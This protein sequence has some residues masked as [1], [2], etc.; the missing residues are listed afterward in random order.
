MRKI[1]AIRRDMLSLRAQSK[2]DADLKCVN[3]AVSDFIEGYKLQKKG[4]DIRV[5]LDPIY[6]GQ[7]SFGV[8]SNRSWV[9]DELITE[10][11]LSKCIAAAKESGR[12]VHITIVDTN[13][14]LSPK[15]DRTGFIPELSRNFTA[16]T[17]EPRTRDHATLCR[18]NLFG[19][20][21]LLIDAVKEGLVTY[22]LV[23]GLRHAGYGYGSEIDAAM[24]YA[25]NIIVDD[26]TIHIVSCSFGGSNPGQYDAIAKKA[27]DAGR[28]VI[29]S[30]AAGN[31]GGD[32]DDDRVG[33]PAKG[34]YYFAVGSTDKN[35]KPSQFSSRGPL[36]D[37]MAPGGSTPSVD[38]DGVPVNWSGTSSACPNLA[39]VAALVYLENGDLNTHENMGAFLTMFAEDML[40]DGRDSV[41]GYGFAYLPSYINQSPGSPS[42]PEPEPDPVLT[43]YEIRM[44]VDRPLCGQ[45]K[46]HES[47]KNWRWLQLSQLQYLASFHGTSYSEVQQMA[48]EV[49]RTYFW[50]FRGMIGLPEWDEVKAAKWIL[51][52]FHIVSKSRGF[53]CWPIFAIIHGE[54]SDIPFI[55]INQDLDD[56]RGRLN[57]TLSDPMLPEGV[58]SVD[59]L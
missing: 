30:A 40:E 56:G 22:G 17:S 42:D 48:D 15:A 16:D 52:F 14:E 7:A 49:V 19:P 37:V 41:S 23:M 51:Q 26:D 13:Y 34:D 58:K 18:G 33:Y 4:E 50:R 24:D 36:L 44:I 31:S 12:K 39:G 38:W 28:R 29:F 11:A 55:I 25:A 54:D 35:R 57:S 20:K 32:P 5:I 47:D 59:L 27:I 21:G 45:W 46:G 10:D 8:L 53:T 6:V 1:S 43:P 9:F 3:Q 2:T